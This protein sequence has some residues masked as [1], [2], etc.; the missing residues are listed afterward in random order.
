MGNSSYKNAYDKTQEDKLRPE[1]EVVYDKKMKKEMKKKGQEGQFG[2]LLST[3]F[4]TKTTSEDAFTRM[5][6]LPRS[7]MIMPFE[8]LKT[9]NSTLLK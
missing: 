3:P 7:S 4:I 1:F 2:S 8:E 5:Y 6:N 9:K